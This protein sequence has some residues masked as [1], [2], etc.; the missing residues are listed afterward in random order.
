MVS[1]SFASGLARRPDDNMTGYVMSTQFERCMESVTKRAV[2]LLTLRSKALAGSVCDDINGY[3]VEAAREVLQ[4]M[5]V[6]SAPDEE[7]LLR[8]VCVSAWRKMSDDAGGPAH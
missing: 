8:A 4:A 3:V 7:E 2:G 6:P 1:F 5:T